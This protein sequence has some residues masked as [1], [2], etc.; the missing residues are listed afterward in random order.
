MIKF[1]AFYKAESPAE[2]SAFANLLEQYNF[3]YLWIPDSHILRREAFVYLTLYAL[4]T[5]RIKLG[6]N[7]ANLSTRHPTLLA[8]GVQSI[9][10]ISG[11]RIVLG[12]GR[13]DSAL[14]IVGGKPTPF[15]EFKQRAMLV[16]ALCNSMETSLDG[17]SIRIP[18]AKGHIPLYIA[19]YGPK[20]LEF[21]GQ[22]A[23]GVIL[24]IAEPTII[25]WMCN[26]VKKGASS[27]GRRIEDLDVV[28]A[29][30]LYVSNDINKARNAARYFPAVVS[31]HVFDLLTRYS[32]SDLPAGLVADMEKIRGKYNYWEHAMVGSAHSKYVS[33]RLVD[34][35]A[36]IG[37][38]NQCKE[39]IQD[40]Q[41]AGVTQVNAY[42]KSDAE[43]VVRTLG[44]KI[45]PLYRE[46]SIEL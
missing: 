15:H 27:A 18:W 16:K 43:D 1:G 32:V 24:Q 29:A 10:E 40:L 31:N 22:I 39:K 26:F 25:E 5:K 45:L 6:L 19:A 33:N 34:S 30:P 8:S 2:A 23:D 46:E 11:G 3:D 20:M 12:I 4:N 37:D 38:I 7:V 21:A 9:D 14:R 35:F 41:K 28:A 13:G 36:I 17:Q 44:E 42:V